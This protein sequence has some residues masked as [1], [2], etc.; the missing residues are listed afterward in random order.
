MQLGELHKKLTERPKL[1]LALALA[2]A[3]LGLLLLILP[4]AGSPKKAKE[5]S[6]DSQQDY[7]SQLAAELEELISLIDGAGDTKVML[8][9]ESGVEN[10]FAEESKS[11]GGDDFS[12]GRASSETSVT[13]IETEDGDS[14]IVRK[15]LEPVIKGVAIVCEGGNTVR[16]R[17]SIVSAVST[18]LGISSSRVSVTGMR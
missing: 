10:V 1:K 6:G 12:G 13:V 2:G 7:A 16:V 11:S 17:E 15:Q 5:Q 9:L 8:T 14:A 3:L 18:V 4:T